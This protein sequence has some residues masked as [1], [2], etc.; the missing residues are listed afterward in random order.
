MNNIGFT[1]SRETA[2]KIALSAYLGE[3]CKFC[4]KEYKTLD[5]LENTVWA[6]PHEHGRLACAECWKK[7]QETGAV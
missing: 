1:V 7:A 2:L 6:G 5:D 3:K 4:G